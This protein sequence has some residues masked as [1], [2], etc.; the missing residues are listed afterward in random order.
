[1]QASMECSACN[2]MD[3][4]PKCIGTGFETHRLGCSQYSKI[5][6]AYGQALPR[7]QLPNC[8]I[9]RAGVSEVGVSGLGRPQRG[10]PLQCAGSAGPLHTFFMS[11]QALPA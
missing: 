6:C 11:G 1:M 4:A 10:G 7:W 3:I 5:V 2:I 9:S 8:K